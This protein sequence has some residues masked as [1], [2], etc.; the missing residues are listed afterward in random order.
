MVSFQAVN[1]DS[2]RNHGLKKAL[3]TSARKAFARLFPQAT[4]DYTLGDRLINHVTDDVNQLSS[5]SDQ[6]TPLWASDSSGSSLFSILSL[7][8]VPEY[9][10]D[11]E[12]H[13]G[14]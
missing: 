8:H 13:L 3:K 1:V 5:T 6:Q 11:N 9:V 4:G 12:G 10:I 14:T 2:K 7:Y